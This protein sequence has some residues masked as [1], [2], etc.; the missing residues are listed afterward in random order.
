MLNDI[1]PYHDHRAG[2]KFHQEWNEM[3]ILL[4][5]GVPLQQRVHIFPNKTGILRF[6]LFD[7]LFFCQKPIY[8]ALTLIETRHNRT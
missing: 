8:K 6:S 2:D 5:F 3:G 1:L 4:L 7:Q